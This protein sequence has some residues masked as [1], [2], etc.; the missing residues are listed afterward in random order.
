MLRRV[1]PFLTPGQILLMV[2][3]YLSTA[4]A[5]GLHPADGVILAEAESN[6][7]DGRIG[8]PGEFQVGFRNVR[9]PIGVYPHSA[10]PAAREVLDRLGTPFVYLKSVAEAALHNPNMIVHTVGA[11]MSIPRIE[12]TH[13]DYCMYHEVFTPSVW[14]LLEALDGEKMRVLERLGCDPVPYVEACKFRNS[15]D[16]A[17]DAKEVFFA[18]AAM[19]E[20]AKGP[21]NVRS[22]YITEDVPQGLGLL[23]SLGAALGVPTPVCSSLIEIA[24][25]ALGCNL[26]AQGR[27]IERLGRDNIRTILDD[28]ER[29]RTMSR[30]NALKKTYRMC[31]RLRAQRGAAGRAICSTRCG[32]ACGTAHH[33]KTTSCSGFLT[34]RTGSARPSS[35]R[36]APA[37]STG[38]STAML[39]RRKRKPSRTRRAFSQC[40]RPMSG[41]RTSTRRRRTLPLS[42]PFWT[43]TIHFF[44]SL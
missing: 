24:S 29:R 2:P 9:N 41:G 17:R 14:N 32:A 31:T 40:S 44:S 18:Y 42:A 27:T 1:V 20:R 25:A 8:A 13:G 26:R 22:R 21:L 43:G 10:L 7:I 15:L 6:F 34:C 37:R 36:A 11:V 38:R 39:R 33:R 28:A 12:A 16:D 23:E 19:P 5:L 35:H 3:G 30:W 4:Y